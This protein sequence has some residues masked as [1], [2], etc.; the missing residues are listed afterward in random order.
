VID[1][2]DFYIQG[3]GNVMAYDLFS[4]SLPA[5]A[6]LMVASVSNMGGLFLEIFLIF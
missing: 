6:D 1:L 4:L 3:K 2:V 5:L